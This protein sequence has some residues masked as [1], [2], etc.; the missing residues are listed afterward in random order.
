MN[1]KFKKIFLKDSNIIIGALHLP[2]LLGYD[3]F[4][5]FATAWQNALSDLNAFVKGGVDGIIFENNYD[6]PHKIEVD[7]AVVASLTYLGQKI[8]QACPVP[9]GVSVLWNDYKAALAIAKVLDLQFIRVPVFVDKV[10]TDYGIVEGQAEEVIKFRQSIG[11]EQVALFTDIHVKHAELLSQTSLV[12]SARLAIRAGSDALI[13]TGKW[14]G[15]AP[16][17]DQLKELRQQIG[18]FPMLVGSGVDQGNIKDLFVWANGAIVSTS[19]KDNKRC[20][21]SINIK[22]YSERIILD[23]V[24]SL[25]SIIS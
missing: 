16:A 23:K 12:E 21:H 17:V 15:N 3:D 10:K 20:N 25:T 8:K 2:P 9:L 18:D 24:K 14:T 4:P 1:S 13:V 5:G 11:A 6:L 22:P 19:V 7:A